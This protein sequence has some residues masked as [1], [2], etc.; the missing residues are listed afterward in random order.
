VRCEQI[1]SVGCRACRGKQ[2][3]EADLKS[4]KEYQRSQASRGRACAGQRGWYGATGCP[5]G[6][7][8]STRALARAADHSHLWDTVVTLLSHCCHTV[9]TLLLNCCYTVGTLLLNCCYTVVTLLLHCSDSRAPL[10][11]WG[12]RKTVVTLLSYCCYTVARAWHHSHLSDSGKDRWGKRWLS[13]I[14]TG[15]QRKHGVSKE[16]R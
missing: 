7:H 6:R 4:T 14:E 5:G 2:S 15:E 9:V 3:V 16:G 13:T 8:R 11:P 12:P 1:G 10:A